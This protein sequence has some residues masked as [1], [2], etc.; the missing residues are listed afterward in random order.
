[1]GAESVRG[2][3]GGGMEQACEVVM[4]SRE[5]RGRIDA[6]TYDKRTTIHQWHRH[7]IGD[8]H[9]DSLISCA[10]ASIRGDAAVADWV[11]AGMSV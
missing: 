4:G 2:G 5:D 3:G 10:C 1:M 7:F 9:Q 8:I 6:Q 11:T